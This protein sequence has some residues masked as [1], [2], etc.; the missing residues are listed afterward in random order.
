M[1]NIVVIA[2]EKVQRYIFQQID[3]NQTDEKTLRSIIL[4]S[5]NVATSILKE[6]EDKFKLEKGA[7]TGEGD[8]IL[9]ISGK[10]VFRSELSKAEI[11][12][13]LKELYQK[14]Y[15]DYKGNIFLNYIV[16]PAEDKE[17]MKILEDADDLLKSNVTKSQVIKDNRELL[18]RFKELKT[19]KQNQVV[20]RQENV[21]DIF[22]TNMDDLVAL[23]EKHETD[24]S[25]GKIAIVKADINNLGKTMK[26]IEDYD[27]YLQLSKLLVEKISLN[28]LKEKI[29]EVEVLKKKMIPFY[30]AGDDIF[31]A[32]RIDAL[33]D[34][35]QVLHS[36]IEEINQTIKDRQ[37]GDN[38]TELS[39]AVGVVL[40]NNHQPIR[41]YRQMVEK[42][43]SQA[44]KKMKTEKAFYSVVGVCMANN[45]FYIYKERF[46]FG[47]NDGFY[48]F[49]R[50]LKELQKMMD[51]RV[52]T[53]T[54]LHKF[55]IN[56][57]IEKNHQEKQMLYTLYFLKPNLQKGKIN[58]I[59]E[60]KELS[61]KYYWLSH[62]MEE[63]RDG[64][65]GG[66]RYFVP[67]KINDILIPK[68]KLVLF[69]LKE[70]YSIPSEDFSYQ[71]II[72][73]G[74]VSLSD[75]RRRI[76]SVMFHKPINYILKIAKETEKENIESLFF[77]KEQNDRKVFYKSV[78][79]DPSIFFRAKNLIETGKKQQ[80]KIM[81]SQYNSTINPSE[82]GG[83]GEKQAK[84]SSE[85]SKAEMTQN[86]HR[87]SFDKNKFIK[88]LDEV[89]G[90][91]WLDRLILLYEY[92]QQRIILKTA[93]KSNRQKDIEKDMNA[94][95][96]KR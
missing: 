27:Q 89:P 72:P 87:F 37:N 88:K 83:K 46:G 14:I 13:N 93:E 78:G 77:R 81:F 5:E 47:E 21:E 65:G 23:D 92:N 44:K 73:S 35:I 31:Y 58:N 15:T 80:V 45:L 3:Q 12:N 57:E 10:V 60:N 61:F 6:I 42:E 74:Q 22:L 29:Y 39:I 91:E 53:R 84:D 75:R 4:A 76:R 62:L 82:N 33:F 26:E 56:L 1:S 51:V 16:F 68:L 85:N 48:R 55:L 49:R 34:S 41:Y 69:F 7:A 17:E 9:W 63:K 8:K 25:N 95:R 28:N 96:E 50:E 43:L 30:V 11:R 40:V 54:A 19:E 24:S 70:R 2:V 38:E 66:E 52:F 32:V 18:F 79:F 64:K 71:Y 90:T 86:V 59:E 20:E 94:K 36:M 67:Q